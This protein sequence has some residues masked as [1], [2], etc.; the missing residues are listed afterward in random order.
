MK[1]KQA[2]I[3]K[4]AKKNYDAYPAFN[5]FTKFVVEEAQVAMEPTLQKSKPSQKTQ[6]VL[7]TQKE[8]KGLQKPLFATAL[9]TSTST[10]TNCLCCKRNMNVYASLC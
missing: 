5:K 7:S 3:V 4:D 9:K 10:R 6:A 1:Q 8:Q 2:R